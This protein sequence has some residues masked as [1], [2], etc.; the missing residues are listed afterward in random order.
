MVN[1]VSKFMRDALHLSQSALEEDEVPV[2][3]L[4]VDSK[5]NS[6]L[7]RGHN[8]TVV[9]SD[10]TNHAEL[11]V[12]RDACIKLNTQRLNGY[13][14]IVTLEPCPMCAQAISFARLDALYFGAYD[15]K[16]GGVEHGCRVFDAPSCH[17]KP[18][19]YGGIL[20]TECATILKGYFKSKR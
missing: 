14:I 19:I 5:S 6:I 9:A 15:I 11:N 16:G 7:A 2:G 20:E 13:S 17:H 4:I 18:D 3:A 8:T 1:D 10:P 12:I